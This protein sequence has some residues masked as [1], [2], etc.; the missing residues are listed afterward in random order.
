MKLCEMTPEEFVHRMKASLEEQL[1]YL[2][3]NKEFVENTRNF[4]RKEIGEKM[5]NQVFPQ[6]RETP[7]NYF[8][9]LHDAKTN[10]VVG[11]L[12]LLIKPEDNTLFIGDIII[13]EEVRGIGY[14]TICLKLIE[15]MGKNQ[16][17]AKYLE[18]HVFKDNLKARKLYLRFGFED[19][20]EDSTG[21]TMAKAIN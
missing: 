13:E 18:L 21:F 3:K 1:N 19:K 2:Y 5:W 9:I 17:A 15:E 12:W 14:G 20:N 7:N 10:M 11:H 16:F 6:G 8:W 4:T